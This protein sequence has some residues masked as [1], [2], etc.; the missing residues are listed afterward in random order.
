MTSKKDK[1]SH[2]QNN[3]LLP[4]TEEYLEQILMECFF[5][6]FTLLF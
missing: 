1:K 5:K 3:N 6:T 4:D 2:R